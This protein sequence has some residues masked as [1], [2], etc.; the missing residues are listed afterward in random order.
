MPSTQTRLRDLP[1]FDAF[2][3]TEFWQDPYPAMA[4][5]Q[6]SGSP[7]YRSSFGAI[8]LG[9][10]FATEIARDPR[11]GVPTSQ[12]ALEGFAQPLIDA[13]EYSLLHINPPE[14]TERRRIVARRFGAA[15]VRDLQ[16]LVETTVDRLLD[17]LIERREADFL[18]ATAGPLTT[19][20]FCSLLDIPLADEPLIERWARDMSV[21]LKVK[22]DAVALRN[23]GIASQSMLDYLGE[24]ASD[25]VSK[26]GK[27]TLS[28]IIE[29]FCEAGY[30]EPARVAAATFAQVMMDGIDSVKNSIANGLYALLLHPEAFATLKQDPSLAPTATEEMLRWDGPTLLTGRRVLEDLDFHG[31]ELSAGTPVSLVWLAANRD[32]LRFPN[33][34]VFDIHRKNNRHAAFGG[35]IHSCAGA[36]LARIQ[37]RIFFE[38]FARRIDRVELAE[39]R[40]QWLPFSIA[41]GLER[42]PIRVEVS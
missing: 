26:G 4:E 39:P 2:L 20:T 32:P 18:T 25:R 36:N 17:E 19:R 23:A 11:F 1:T 22:P 40:P 9:F 38:K 14:H 30:K 16:P 41:R 37:L 12:Q 33:A 13:F 5:A 35:G 7:L 28:I 31:V 15:P 27:D 24:L 42:L 8:A 3:E 34:D 29:G 21:G 10:D 6:Q